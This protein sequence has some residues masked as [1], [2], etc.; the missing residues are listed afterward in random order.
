VSATTQL[1]RAVAHAGGLRSALSRA[2]QLLGRFPMSVTQ[3]ALRIAVAWPFWKSGQTKWAGW[4]ELSDSAVYLFEEEFRLHL[5]GQQYAYPLP[6]VAAFA[7]GAAEI[8]LPLML[9]AGLGTRVAA[10][11]I[12]L[13]T[14][15]IQLTVPDGW[16]TYHL[17]WAAMALAIMTYGPGKLSVDHVL[18]RAARRHAPAARPS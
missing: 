17:P 2:E 1:P 12:L 10:L 3:L 8:I 9:V 7:A 15:V 16:A 14:A 13:M 5:F 11:G 4:F 6:Q 18:G